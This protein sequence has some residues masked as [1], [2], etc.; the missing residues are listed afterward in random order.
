MPIPDNLRSDHLFLLMGANPLPNW[1][2]AQLLVNPRGTIHLA[3]TAKTREHARRLKETL[4]EEQTSNP[5]AERIQIERF[6]TAEADAGKIFADVARRAE[7]LPLAKGSVI[8]LHYTGGTK[9]MS[10]HA[11]RAISY[12]ARE[13]G[14]EVSLSYL[15]AQS[16]QMKFDPPHGGSFSIALAEHFQRCR[17]QPER[18]DDQFGNGQRQRA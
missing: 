12:T 14:W 15:E 16:L 11:H 7:V 6:E 8:G 2:A 17:P 3:Y 9:M 5:E 10:V 18:P 1:V 4:E 13:R